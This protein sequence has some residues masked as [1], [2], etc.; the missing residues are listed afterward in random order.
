MRTHKRHSLWMRCLIVFIIAVCCV[1]CAK[2]PEALWQEQYDFGVH[3]LE[4]GDYEQAILA[5]EAA[6]E[7][8]PKRPDPYL[9]MV[10]I[11]LTLGDEDA[12]LEWAVRGAEAAGDEAL[13]QRVEELS[14]CKHEW[15]EATFTQPETCL[16]CGETQGKPKQT[17]FA[18]NNILVEDWPISGELPAHY[19]SY[20]PYDF[21]DYIWWGD[22][23]LSLTRTIQPA[24]EPGYKKVVLNLFYNMPSRVVDK[25]LFLDNNLCDLYTG[26]AYQNK[27]TTGNAEYG[28]EASIPLDDTICR[29][30]YACDIVWSHGEQYYS[31]EYGWLGNGYCE[32]TYDIVMPDEYDGLVLA[33]S[34][35]DSVLPEDIVSGE[36]AETHIMDWSASK[37]G[38]TCFIY[39]GG[40]A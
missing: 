29:I 5:F 6:I 40:A 4:S 14:A 38:N 26:I 15:S 10:D 36:V 27:E 20:N 31:N 11:Y 35:K 17:A 37:L 2:S 18:A 1:S 39:V 19:L 8:D 7:I 25:S 28:Y 33:L 24:E 12:A 13:L 34:M 23:V 16:K 9:Q 32:M 22:G 30:H 21:E 3:Y